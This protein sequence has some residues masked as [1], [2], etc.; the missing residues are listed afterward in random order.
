MKH[1]P[2]IS[3]NLLREVFTYF[4]IKEIFILYLM[5]YK[6]LIDMCGRLVHDLVTLILRGRDLITNIV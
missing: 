5:S 2:L 6:L 3:K 4:R 1:L